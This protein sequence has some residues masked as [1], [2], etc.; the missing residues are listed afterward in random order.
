[1][2]RFFIDRPIFAWVI[3]IVI[4]LAGALSIAFLPVAQYPDIAPPQINISANY[5]G[6]S[7]DTAENS[8][9]QVIEQQ[10]TGLDGLIYFTSTSDANGGIGISA[11]FKAGINPDIAQVQVQNK[12][13]LALPR[14]PQ[15]VQRAG[16]FVQKA[17]AGFLMICA[18]YDDSGRMTT[19][20]IGD[21]V[22][23]NLYDP[24]SRITGVGQ[25][26]IF[27]GQYAIRIWLDPYKLQQYSLTTD[28]ISAAV[29]RLSCCSL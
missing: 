7:P 22:G 13:Q 23:T 15:E 14:L 19:S 27:G 21:Y 28:D 29:V 16:V 1:M 24:V 11:V 8:V 12:L 18:L 10:L 2:S 25:A 9:T 26:Q 6:A 3:A 17:Q 5:P 4:M 20:D